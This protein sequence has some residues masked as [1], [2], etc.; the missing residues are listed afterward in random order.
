MEEQKGDE[1]L[2]IFLSNTLSYPEWDEKLP[3]TVVIKFGDAHFADGAVFGSCGFN[4]VAGLTFVVFL[5]DDFVVV[6]VI[7]FDLFF[8]ILLGD[9]SRGYRA[10]LVVDPETDK[11]KEVG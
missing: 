4:D 10:G 8:V 2:I 11:G 1:I 3:D 5:V 9:L 7:F 6:W